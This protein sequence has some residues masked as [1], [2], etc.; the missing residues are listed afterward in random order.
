MVVENNSIILTDT[1]TKIFFFHINLLDK[2]NNKHLRQ[3]TKLN[4][5]NGNQLE[6]TI[7]YIL[8]ECKTILV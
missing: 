4:K 6:Y 1:N 8:K 5:E 7:L 2:N 3:K